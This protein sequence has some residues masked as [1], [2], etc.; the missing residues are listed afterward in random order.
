[1]L[2]YVLHEV[3][4]R[5][6]LGGF[7]LGLAVYEHCQRKA[8]RSSLHRVWLAGEGFG[9][10]A[11]LGSVGG[12]GPLLAAVARRRVRVGEDVARSPR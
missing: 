6:L 3:A 2:F 12:A 9:A 8:V 7:L 11:L 10:G 4:L 1:M 5:R